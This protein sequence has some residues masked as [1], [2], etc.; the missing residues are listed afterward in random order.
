MFV[1]A[2][3]FR[4]KPDRI[5][6][7][8]KLIDWQSSRSIAEEKG[9]LQFDVCQRENEPGT[10]LLYEVYTDAAAFDEDHLNVPRFEAFLGRA[11]PMIEGDPVITRFNRLF[12]NA[13]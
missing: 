3:D 8:K 9:C 10:F 12:A 6:D 7:F 2:A 1:V 5:E 13:K 4:I 11:K